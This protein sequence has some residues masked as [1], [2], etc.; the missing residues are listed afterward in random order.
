GADERL[1]GTGIDV[2]TLAEIDGAPGIAVEAGVEQA[3]RVLERGAL[4]EGQLHD[5]FIALAG[6]D[7]AVVRPHRNPSPLPLLDHIGV[8]LP[9]ERADASEHLAPPVAQLLDPRGD[10]LRRR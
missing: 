6:A 8:R 7:D 9:D 4:E 3:R 5:A 1:E 10:E 2:I